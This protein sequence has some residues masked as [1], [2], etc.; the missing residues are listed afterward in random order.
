[1]ARPWFFLFNKLIAFTYNNPFS[2]RISS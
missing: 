2:V 1:V